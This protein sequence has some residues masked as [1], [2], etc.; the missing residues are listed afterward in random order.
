MK[1][2]SPVSFDDLNSPSASKIASEDALSEILDLARHNRW[3]E[4]AASAEQITRQNPNDADAFYWLGVARLELHKPI[5]AVQA[6]RSAQ[7][8]GMD[9]SKLHE[10]LGRA[11]YDL[12]QF[13]LFQQ[14]MK[15]A[16]RLDPL[17]FRPNY[18]LGLYQITIR[19]DVAT[20]LAFF[21]KATKLQP[22]DWKSLYQEGRCLELSGKPGEARAYYARAIRS[23]EASNQPFGWPFQGMA[24]LLINQDPEQ[25]LNFA[26]KAATVEPNEYSNHLILAQ[27]YE[28]L[29]KLP[30][31]LREAKLAASQSPN[32]AQVRYLLFMLYRRAGKNQAAQSE[33]SAFKKLKIVY[34]SE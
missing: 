16:S 4:L 33:L 25:A 5:G 27:V 1:A 3:N 18:F 19:S 8:L 11:Y 29:G 13:I 21:D 7:N 24:H 6:L 14:Q 22:D 15:E 28:R 34:G 26:K 31:A 2:Q 10:T 17:N 12:N 30:E 20:A 32:T 9:S 23:I